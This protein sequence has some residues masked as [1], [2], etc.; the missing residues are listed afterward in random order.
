MLKIRQQD[1][2][3]FEIVYSKSEWFAAKLGNAILLAY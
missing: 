3:T 1:H 2:I